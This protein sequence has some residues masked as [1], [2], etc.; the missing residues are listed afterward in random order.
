MAESRVPW[1]RSGLGGET[2]S[3]ADRRYQDA[4]ALLDETVY[5]IITAALV[6][7][8]E[9]LLGMLMAGMPTTAVATD[10][11]LRK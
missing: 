8:K 9:D 10:Q 3:D 4:I 2:S 6:G 11:Q 7:Q 1:H 5:A